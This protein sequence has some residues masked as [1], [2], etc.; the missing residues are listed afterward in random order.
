MKLWMLP[1]LSLIAFPVP[2]AWAV[3]EPSAGVQIVAI[4]PVVIFPQATS[5]DRKPVFTPDQLKKRLHSFIGRTCDPKEIAEWLARPYRFLGYVPNIQIECITGIL[6][7]TV[8]ESNQTIDLITFDE[9]ELSGLGLV[10]DPEFT[11]DRGLYPVPPKTPRAVLRGLLQTSLGDL[12]NFERYRNENGALGRFGYVIAVVPGTAT[13]PDSLPR[14]AYL[15]Q[16]LRPQKTPGHPEEQ[17]T[18]YLGGVASYQPRQGASF[19]VRYEKDSLFFPLDRLSVVPDYNTALGGEL[20]YMA[21]LLATHKRP[22]RLYDLEFRAYSNFVHNRVL[23]GVE[24]DE[25]QSGGAMT[26]GFRPL[27]LKAPHTLRFTAG[28]R[29][30]STDLE[31]TSASESGEDLA[32]LRLGAVYEWRHNYRWPSLFSRI[33]PSVD[34]AF[35]VAGGDRSFVKPGLDATLHQRFLSGLETDFRFAAGTLTENVPS[36]ELW[37][38]GGES[39]LRGFPQDTLLGRHMA[40]LQSELWVPLF[41][42]APREDGAASDPT[43]IPRPSTL[44][45]R[46]ARLIKGAVFVD[47]GTM[48]GISS[49]GSEAALGTGFGLRFLVPRNPIVLRLDYGWGFGAPDGGPHFYFA[50]VYH[51]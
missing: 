8:L 51:P 14:A 4:A 33:S 19:G 6:S 23:D 9:S 43:A 39:T 5:T 12:Y 31:Q 28:I 41:W 26:L 48:S 17:K 49:G 24:T 2:P 42:P 34:F 22:R 50:L 3:P 25:R 15:V 36:F 7:A 11:E 16:S 20:S 32:I 10:R 13:A 1:A 40:D 47:A 29:Y 35:A 38:L 21:P 18:N 27:Y 46:L 44:T 37:S 30:E 45:P